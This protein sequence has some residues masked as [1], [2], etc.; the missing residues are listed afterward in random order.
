MCAPFVL[1]TFPPRAG[2]TLSARSIAASFRSRGDQYFW[3]S[4]AD[5]ARP[6]ALREASERCAPVIARLFL[7]LVLQPLPP[8][9]AERRLP[10]KGPFARILNGDL[11]IAVWLAIFCGG[12]RNT[13]RI[14]D[15][16]ATTVFVTGFRQRFARPLRTSFTTCGRTPPAGR[17]LATPCYP[18]SLPYSIQL[19]FATSR[20]VSAEPFATRRFFW[21]LIRRPSD[22]RIST[23][24]QH[25][26]L[27]MSSGCLS[28]PGFEGFREGFQGWLAQG[29]PPLHPLADISLRERGNLALR[30]GDG[31]L[32]PL[33]PLLKEGD[34]HR[35]LHLWMLALRGRNLDAWPPPSLGD[36]GWGMCTAHV[37][38]ALDSRPLRSG[39]TG[40]LGG[41]LYGL[42]RM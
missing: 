37:C 24:I 12:V 21:A 5:V 33:I 32:P 30:E 27:R 8:G 13:P 34:V 39:M 15:A 1:R 40:R 3:S 9:E 20:R 10:D 19:C 18:R 17:V 23:V 41:H 35:P 2:E 7:S 38:F 25:V 31:M 11:L 28:E 42:S 16:S 14:R 26:L 29:V 22:Q 6:S 36:D 4:T